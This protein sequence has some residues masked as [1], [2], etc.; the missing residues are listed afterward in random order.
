MRRPAGDALVPKQK[1]TKKKVLL[2][3]LLVTNT[4]WLASTVLS[5]LLLGYTV[6]V[7]NVEVTQY[8]HF[9]GH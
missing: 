1:G 7:D 2:V 6:E 5:S 4:I 9:V 3:C 8:Q